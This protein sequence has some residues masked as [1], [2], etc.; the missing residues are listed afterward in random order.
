MV[1]P[2]HFVLDCSE[3]VIAS[4]TGMKTIN[5]QQDISY[6]HAIVTIRENKIRWKTSYLMRNDG[7]IERHGDYG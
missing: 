2:M 4:A 3:N 7:Q 5:M 1:I 6:M